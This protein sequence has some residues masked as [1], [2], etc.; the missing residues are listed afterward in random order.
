MSSLLCSGFFSQNYL[1]T[2]EIVHEAYI[3]SKNT[4]Y[5]TVLQEPLHK[6]S[7]A[8]AAQLAR[9]LHEIKLKG[10]I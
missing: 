3:L 2:R 1:S 6:N 5:E 7:F 4:F 8:D 10:R 9:L